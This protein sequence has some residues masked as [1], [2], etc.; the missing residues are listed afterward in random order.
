MKEVPLFGLWWLW[1]ISGIAYILIDALLIRSIVPGLLKLFCKSNYF[2]GRIN[3][4]VL[5]GHTEAVI[6]ERYTYLLVFLHLLCSFRI[7]IAGTAVVITVIG[8][9][10]IYQT[11]HDV[12]KA[13]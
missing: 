11:S 13:R 12:I 3:H 10:I 2:K 8:I 9:I 6:T 1:I 4:K 5:P 7:L